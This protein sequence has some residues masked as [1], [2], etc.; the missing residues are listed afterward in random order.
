[1]AS[2][3]KTLPEETWPRFPGES[4]PESLTLNAPTLDEELEAD[5]A[6][7]QGKEPPTPEGQIPQMSEEGLAEVHLGLHGQ[8]DLHVG[9]HPTGS[10][11][12]N[13]PDDLHAHT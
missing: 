2:K 10:S 11:R 3:K 13:A 5:W 12:P 8:P 1:V 9:E 6:R 7:V 4:R